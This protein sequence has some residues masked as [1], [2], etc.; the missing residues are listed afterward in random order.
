M[1]QVETHA[2]E[3]PLTWLYYDHN[4]QASLYMYMY[5]INALPSNIQYSSYHT[6]S[7]LDKVPRLLCCEPE[8]YVEAV[9]IT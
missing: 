9:H 4:K 6:P 3:G 7:P 2:M 8:E 5:M 1:K